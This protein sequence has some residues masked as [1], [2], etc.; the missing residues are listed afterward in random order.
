MKAVWKGA[1]AFGLVNIPVKLYSVAEPKAIS[2]R[3]LCGKC[4]SPLRYKRW[5]DKCKKEVSWENVVKGIEYARGKYFVITRD[6]LKKLRP[7]KSDLIEIMFFT[8]KGS[9]D[10]IYIG[11]RYYVV[12]DKAGEKA[13][14]LLKEVLQATAKIAIGKFVMKEKQ[15]LCAIE[16]YKQGLLLTTLNYA[17]EV[18]PIDLIEE[19]KITP[20]LGK[21]E[22]ALAKELIKKLYEEEF[23]INAFKDEFAEGLKELIKKMI[24]G[25]KIVVKKKRKKKKLTL[26]QALKASI[27]K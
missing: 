21:K 10:P 12:P 6:V 27:G 1:I 19:L 2:F 23:D 24:K 25:E 4:R 22:L 26:V 20:K 9:I 5:C 16:S 14:F 18:R 15:Y 17:Y 11:R 13:Y 7:E 8:D 3:L